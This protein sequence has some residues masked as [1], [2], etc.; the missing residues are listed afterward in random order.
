MPP[1]RAGGRPPSGAIVAIQLESLERRA[2]LAYTITSLGQVFVSPFYSGQGIVAIN[3]SV[4]VAATGG[5][6]GSSPEA[7]YLNSNG[8]TISL[9]PL[10]GYSS[11]TATDVNASGQVSGY[12]SKNSG[13][14]IGTTI[15]EA[16]LYNSQ[17]QATDLGNLG[18]T[19][20]ATGIDDWDRS[21]AT[22]RPRPLIMLPLMP[23]F[24]LGGGS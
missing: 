16:V 22:R 15:N 17:G 5:S 23:S 10:S 6:P 9:P 19:S 13:G 4:D 24:T 14:G 21:S 11:S 1:R 8:Q 7:Y 2:L 12:S 18:D 20:Q 3:A